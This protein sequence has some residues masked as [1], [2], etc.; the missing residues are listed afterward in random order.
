MSRIRNEPSVL[1]NNLKSLGTIKQTWDFTARQPSSRLYQYV[2]AGQVEAPCG[3]CSSAH[4]ANSVLELFWFEQVGNSLISRNMSWEG[5]PD[6]LQGSQHNPNLGSIPS[7]PLPVAWINTSPGWIKCLLGFY[8]R[9]GV[10]DI[11][12]H[13]QY[14][15]TY[16]YGNHKVCTNY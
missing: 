12:I 1:S 10:T 4:Q 9:E 14:T 3:S 5:K 11:H 8:T 7:A 2:C 13:I 6:N 16:T 15:Y